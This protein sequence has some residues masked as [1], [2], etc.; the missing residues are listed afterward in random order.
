MRG[1]VLSPSITGRGRRNS[2]KLRPA[3]ANR[4]AGSSVTLEARLGDPVHVVRAERA[5]ELVSR[6]L[7]RDAAFRGI[8]S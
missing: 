6:T 8:R 5:S 2:A 4:K 7:F 1:K 3:A